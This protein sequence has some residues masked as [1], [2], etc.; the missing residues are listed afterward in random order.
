M[1]NPLTLSLTTTTLLATGPAVPNS[2]FTF[3][4]RA[5]SIRAWARCLPRTYP[6]TSPR[7]PRENSLLSPFETMFH[8]VD[9][10]A[11][12]DL[13]SAFSLN[14]YAEL[15]SNRNV[16]AHEPIS[17]VGITKPPFPALFPI[18]N[19]G[20]ATPT[21][22][23]ITP[24]QI[25]GPAHGS[26]HS[27]PLHMWPLAQTRRAHPYPYREQGQISYYSP[28]FLIPHYTSERRKS[29]SFIATS[30][31]AQRSRYARRTHGPTV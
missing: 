25:V 10:L 18:R 3:R 13:E 5:R 12:T 17:R 9:N 14:S 6:Q 20:F 28:L 19:P 24:S 4:G 16:P 7:R 22:H 26:T 30:Q 27:H 1:Y 29:N 23:P 11:G 8:P 2:N 31:R 21:I 15:N